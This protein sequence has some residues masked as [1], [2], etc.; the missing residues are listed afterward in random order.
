MKAA[1]DGVKTAQDRIVLQLEIIAQSIMGLP[2][3]A[4]HIRNEWEKG[5]A[6]AT[7]ALYAGVYRRERVLLKQQVDDFELGTGKPAIA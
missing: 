5:K 7:T 3:I 4:K 6:A 2:A 1:Q